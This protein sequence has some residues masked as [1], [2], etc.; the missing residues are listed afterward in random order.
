MEGEIDCIR[1]TFIECTVADARRKTP[2]G[3]GGAHIGTV[4]RQDQRAAADLLQ[5]ETA[6]ALLSS[7]QSLFEG[8]QEVR[9]D[10]GARAKIHGNNGQR[11]GFAHGRHTA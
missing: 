7:R 11:H 1:S 2:G 5:P 3:V 4:S 6:A 10:C 8:R 9:P